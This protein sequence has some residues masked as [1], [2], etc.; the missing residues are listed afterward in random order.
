M[1]WL[2]PYHRFEIHSPLR[3]TEAARVI[4]AHTEAERFFRFSWPNPANDTRF[5]GEI[6][7][8]SFTVR[9][10]IGYRNSFLP[11]VEGAIAQSARGS[12]VTIRMR[13]MILVI[14]FL[15]LWFG[16]ILFA[17]GSPAWPIALVMLGFAYLMT[18]AG[19]WFEA[20]KQ[21]QTLRALFQGQPAAATPKIVS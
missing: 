12:L 17:L 20:N 4:A 11:V 18:L 15:A 3:P 16:G 7:G 1:K 21:E 2:A 8:D 13:P 5:E 10:V 19:F 6:R 14:V 9:R